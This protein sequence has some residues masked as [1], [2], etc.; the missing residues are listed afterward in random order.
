[1]TLTFSPV[2]LP[3]VLKGRRPKVTQEGGD[4]LWGMEATHKLAQA[5]P[6]VAA[7]ALVCFLE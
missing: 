1:M 4:V 6:P 5:H 3:V 2:W 7:G